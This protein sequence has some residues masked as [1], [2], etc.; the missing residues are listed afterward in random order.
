MLSVAPKRIAVIV[1]LALGLACSSDTP[2]GPG[3]DPIPVPVTAVTLDR[4]TVTAVPAAS[5]KL[6]ATATGSGQTLNRTITW[7]SSDISKATVASD[8]T[9]TAVAPGSATITATAE[10]ISGRATITVLDGGLIT[11]SGG[12]VHAASNAVTLVAPANAVSANTSIVVQ[13]ASG[14]P[15]SAGLIAGTTFSL[16]PATVTFSAAVTL[17]IRYSPSALGQIPRSSLALYILSNGAWQL[18]SGSSVDSANAAVSAAISRLG[19]FAIIG[20]IPP[21]PVATVTLS[22]DTASIVP[23]ASVKLTATAKS[24]DGQTLE[25]TITWSSSDVAKATVA[26][27]G[28]VTG[29]APGSAIVTATSEGKSASATITILAPP[30]APVGSITLDVTSLSLYSGL[31]RQVTATLRDSN[32]SVLDGRIIAWQSSNSSVANVTSAGT[33]T[34]GAFGTATI[35]ATS[36]GKSAT[37]SVSVSMTQSSSCMGSHRRDRSGAR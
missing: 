27:D 28:T 33:I 22:S 26:S 9:V 8:G 25:R 5:V 3:P 2:V 24:S 13:P 29:V 18:I 12:T 16:T 32:G 14:A 7:S 21:A 4:D 37:V 20:T 34:S 17:T 36:E 35:T 6:N 11:A 1:T 10:G 30:P 19:T 23:G 15:A 31:T